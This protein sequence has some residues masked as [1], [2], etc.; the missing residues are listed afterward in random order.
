[1]YYYKL[2]IDELISYQEWEQP[3]TSSGD[4]IEEVTEE[5]YNVAIAATEQIIE[6]EEQSKDEQIAALEE[7]NAALLYKLLTGEDLEY[8]E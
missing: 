3:L 5:E 8:E 2:N 4:N 6:Q 1:M 7:E